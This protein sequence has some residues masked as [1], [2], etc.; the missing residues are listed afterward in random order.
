MEEEEQEENVHRSTVSRQ[1]DSQMDRGEGGGGCV[2]C[3]PH[4]DVHDLLGAER[5]LQRRARR[6]LPYRRVSRL[7]T[8]TIVRR[9]GTVT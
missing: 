4:L 3:R 7:A 2:E 5:L 6:A 8:R 1:S 9:V